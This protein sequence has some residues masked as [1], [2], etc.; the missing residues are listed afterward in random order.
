M[1]VC[2]DFS[3]SLSV[4]QQRVQAGLSSRAQFMFVSNPESSIQFGNI[5]AYLE[6]YSCVNFTLQLIVSIC[7]IDFFFVTSLGVF[8]GQYQ[9]LD[10]S[11]VC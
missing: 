5:T 11:T 8:A 9:G 10:K 2:L 7:E 3:Y 4:E 6:T 1:I